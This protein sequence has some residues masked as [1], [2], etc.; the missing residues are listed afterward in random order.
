VLRKVTPTVSSSVGRRTRALG[1]GGR[2]GVL[3]ART[4]S[5]WQVGAEVKW[6]SVGIDEVGDAAIRLDPNRFDKFG[7]E[8][9]E[10]VEFVR[11]LVDLTAQI[12]MERSGAGCA[13]LESDSASS[14]YVAQHD[15]AVA[16]LAFGLDEIEST[17]PESGE[18]IRV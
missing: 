4:G 15:P 10:S 18:R 7:A 16:I 12:E 9:Q 6:V 11:E 1:C 17:G 3:K 13:S 8:I 2:K 14:A 5:G